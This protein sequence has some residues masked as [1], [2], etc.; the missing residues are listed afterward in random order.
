MSED[1][2]TYRVL[3]FGKEGCQKCEVLK[4]R[5]GKTLAKKEW[6]D[7]EKQY[8]SVKTVDGLIAFSRAQCVNPSRIPAMVV[9]KRDPETGDYAFLP[10]PAPG[11]PDAVCMKSKLY[12]YLGLQTDYSTL[13]KGVISSKMITAV[14][15]QALEL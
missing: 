7:F 3:I 6:A 5:L 12:Q 4:E 10:N 9:T 14:L 13:G 8:L 15:G 1:A 2:K 11:V